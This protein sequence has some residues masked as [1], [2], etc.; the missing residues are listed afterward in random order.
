VDVIGTDGPRPSRT[1]PAMPIGSST[2]RAST[3]PERLR[4]SVDFVRLMT[5]PA[6]GVWIP[7]HG[8]ARW[9]VWARSI[10]TGWIED[11][12]MIAAAGVVIDLR[13]RAV[14]ACRGC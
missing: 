8:A 4:L 1:T 7:I 10:G 5:G 9:I 11:G 3:R 12:H 6:L 13:L 14:P 2:A